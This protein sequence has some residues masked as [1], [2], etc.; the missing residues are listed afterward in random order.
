MSGSNLFTTSLSTI[1]A[2]AFLFSTA[3]MA[4]ASSDN[5]NAPVTRDQLPALVKEV[6]LSDPTILTQVIEKMQENQANIMVANAKEA[7]AKNKKEIFSDPNSP[8]VGSADADVT[9]VEFFDYHC[10]YCKQ[11][12]ISL[13]KLMDSDK[14]IRVVFKEYPI[15]S[16]N[17][18]LA[19][20]AALAV[21]RIAKDKYFDFHKAMLNV[22]GMISESKILEEA[23]KLGIS[24]DKMKKEISNPEIETIL[25]K[26]KDLGTT[27]G[28]VGTPSIII[29]DN[30]YPGA[31]SF[32]AMQ[33]AVAEVRAAKTNKK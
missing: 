26:N 18:R 32:E 24:E 12:F 14:K 19:S 21:N 6:L 11:A 5:K 9:V 20:K 33:K 30:F 3:V 10:G 23:K 7:I 17:S 1:L 29:G 15:L 13:S 28:A 31:M 25:N 27:I 8:V 22:N 2:S 4:Q 16:D